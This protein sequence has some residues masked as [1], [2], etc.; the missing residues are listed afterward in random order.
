MLIAAA[1]PSFALAQTFEAYGVD[2][3][4]TALAGT[5]GGAAGE[6]GAVFY[7][8]AAIEGARAAIAWSWSKP[9][10]RVSRLDPTDEKQLEPRLPT[11]YGG[12]T[13]GATVPLPGVFQNR[14]SLGAALYLPQHRYLNVRLL[15]DGTPSLM[16]YDS[17]PE[18]VQ[19]T[20][21][22]AYRPLDWLSVGAGAQLGI[23]IGG[24]AAL[25]A[26]LAQN[27]PGR[28]IRRGFS[29]EVL[30][31][32]A[33]MAGFV[34]GPFAHL[35]FHGT[36]RG[37]LRGDFGM[38]VQ[39]DLQQY[40]LFEVM[41]KGLALYTP[42]TFVAG[43]SA[44]LAGD[45]LGLFADLAYERWSRMPA[46][47]VDYQLQLSEL[48]T[49]LGI[50]REVKSV[51]VEPDFRDVLVPRLGARWTHN[52]RL[53]LRGGYFFRSSATPAQSGTTNFLDP[54][55]H[56]ISAGVGLGMD[57]PL[58]LGR[59][60][61]LDLGAQWGLFVPE[62]IVKDGPNR[63]PSYRMSGSTIFLSAAAGFAW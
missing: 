20:T 55:E 43:A 35:R 15:D 36:W 24:E 18:R 5:Q 57:D 34:V 1:L 10:L 60:V 17:A 13:L 33:P 23:A 6:L 11:D 14:I 62:Q 53:E 32:V 50:N 21:A 49:A 4:S 28:V 61:S 52:D 8:P 2:S 16:R 63:L 30:P 22:V 41:A 45:R 31:V 56:V 39:L 58:R 44:F 27:T 37:E 42:E 29:V 25:T 47:L 54:A 9:A 26:V 59:R 40:G 38:P 12:L 48:F 3:R 51:A 7:S 46:P 19:G